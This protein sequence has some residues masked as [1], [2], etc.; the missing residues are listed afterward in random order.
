MTA[1]QF[2]FVVD[3]PYRQHGRQRG[4]ESHHAYDD[5]F[6]RP[7]RHQIQSI[8]LVLVTRAYASLRLAVERA[9][10][11]SDRIAKMTNGC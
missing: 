11:N 7:L 10:S 9:A 5:V 8:E 3:L 6:L 2:V 4:S 1:H